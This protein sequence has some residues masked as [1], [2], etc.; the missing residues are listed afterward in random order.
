[1]AASEVDVGAVVVVTEEAEVAGVDSAVVVALEA[2]VVEIVAVVD[3]EAAVVI[4][5]VG[6]GAEGARTVEDSAIMPE[7]R[8]HSI[9]WNLSASDSI[10]GFFLGLG[11]DLSR[12]AAGA[13]RS[14]QVLL[15]VQLEWWR[16][17]GRLTRWKDDSCT[18]S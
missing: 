10:R 18:S 3:E 1:M 4:E 12:W 13:A 2:V 17:V 15:P 5:E 16:K 7:E 14:L 6:V 9:E 11:Q 8:P